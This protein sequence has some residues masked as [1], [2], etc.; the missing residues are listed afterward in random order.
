M[1]YADALLAAARDD[2]RIV[3][4]TAENRAAIR[5]LPAELG[6][7]FIDVGIAEQTLVG[8]AAGLALRGRIPVVHA[9]AAFLTMRAFEFIRTDVGIPRLPVKVVGYVPGLLS[10]GNG[11]THQAI[12]DIGI[13]RT[14]PDLGIFC[15]ADEE[16]LVHGI[17]E[18]LRD[19]RP[20]YVRYTAQPP[21]VTHLD[22]PR[23]GRAEVLA[24]GTDVTLLAHGLLL[25]EAARARAALVADGI[26]VGLVNVRYLV[27]LDEE[28]V[29]SAALRSRRLLIV[30]DHRAVG[31]LYSAVAELLVRNRIAADVRSVSLGNRWFSPGRLPAILEK[32]GLGAGAIAARARELVHPPQARGDLRVETGL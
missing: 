32:E 24:R 28:A 14:I 29:V 27:P 30:E 2:S 11:A 19:P 12:E 17:Q 31:G 23:L 13:L 15:P 8:A 22:R 18:I 20:W 9:L 1:N 6:P 16:D 25:G 26:S 10:D 4:M 5:T 7:R 3:V 21:A